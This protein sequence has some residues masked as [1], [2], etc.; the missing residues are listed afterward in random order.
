MAVLN[1]KWES[2]TRVGPADAV[3]TGEAS[4]GAKS[5]KPKADQPMM[6]Y[7]TDGAEDSGFDKVEKVILMDSKVCVGMWAFKCIKMSPSDVRDDPL[8]SGHGTETPRFIFVSHDYEDVDDV[9]GSKLKTKSVYETMKKFAKKAYTTNF[10]KNVKA[11][12]KVLIEFDKINNGK[13]VLDEKEKRLGSDI[14]KGDAKK[15]ADEKDELEERQKKADA[16]WAELRKFEL[17]EP[18]A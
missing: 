17:K 8:L 7:V 11:T 18:K 6:I 15:I 13:K 3:V 12:L 14:S 9:E 1:K 10:D 2:A 5:E 4:E 16:E